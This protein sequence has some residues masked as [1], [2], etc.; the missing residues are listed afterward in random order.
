[1]RERTSIGKFMYVTM[2]PPVPR[3]K[4][5][6]WD[7]FAGN[8]DALLGT[9]AWCASWRQYEFR[10]EPDTGF[11]AGCLHDLV[12]FIKHCRDRYR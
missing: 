5:Q 10:P 4:T 3:C 9:V 8:G 2:R 6:Q 7:V 12:E 1:M 11:S